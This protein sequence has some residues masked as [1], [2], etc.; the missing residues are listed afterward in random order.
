[1]SVLRRDR[2]RSCQH[3]KG[4]SGPIKMGNFSNSQLVRSLSCNLLR[5]VSKLLILSFSVL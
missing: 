4:P 3:G 5:E 1:V 2:Q